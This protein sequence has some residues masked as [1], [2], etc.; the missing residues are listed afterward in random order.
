MNTLS[1]TLL[2]CI[3]LGL[4]SVSAYARPNVLIIISDDAGYADFGFMNELTGRV[5]D[6]PTPHLDDLRAEGTLFSSAYTGSV[7]S[8]SR[9]AITTGFYQNRLG[10]EYNINNLISATARDGHFPETVTIFEWMKHLGYTTGA[11]GKWHI[12]AMADDGARPG[13]R[14]ER[15]GVDTFV[16][17][18]GGSRN[19]DVGVVTAPDQLLRRTKVAPD[20]TITDTV[21]ENQHPWKD[22][23]LTVAFG[24]AAEDFITE[25]HDD[26][27]PFLL[28]AAFTSPHDPLHESPDYDDPRIAGISDPQHRQYASM[29]LTMDKAIGGILE[30]LDDPDRDGNPADSIRDNTFIIF[31]NDNGGPSSN[32]SSNFPLRGR[33]G[34]PEEGGIRVPMF[35]T[36]A[37]IPSNSVYAAPVHSVDFLPTIARLAGA[38]EATTLDGVSLAEMDGVDLI[39]YLNENI[40]TAPHELIVVRREDRVG[41]RKGDWKL[42]AKAGSYRLYNLADDIGETQDLALSEPAI[43]AD[44]LHELNLFDTGSDK[45]RHA[46]L[47]ALPDSINLNDRFIA[48]PPGPSGS[49]FV[50]DLVIVGGSILNGDFNAGAATGIET[51]AQTMAWDNIGTSGASAPAT[52]TNLDVDGTR[53]AILARIDTRTFGLDTGYTLAGG[54]ILHA[55]YEWRDALDWTDAT[56]RV[57]VTLFTTDDDTLTGERTLIESGLSN[58]SQANDT[59][60]PEDHVFSPIPAGFAGKRLFIQLNPELEGS[61]FARLDNF[62]LERGTTTVATEGRFVWGDPLRWIDGDTG[63]DDTLL[64]TDGFPGARLNFPSRPFNYTA[65]NNLE[66]MTGLGFMLNE[67]SFTGADATTLSLDGKG[68]VFA[69]GLDGAE[70]RINMELDNGTVVI[71]P[72]LL[73]MNDLLLTGNGNGTLRIGGMVTDEQQPNQLVKDGEFTLQFTAAAVNASH[74]VVNAG[75]LSFGET[76]GL[77]GVND[78]SLNATLQIDVSAGY[79]D[80]L[81]VDGTLTLA[82][83][84]LEIVDLGGAFPTQA[85]IAV[86]YGALDGEFTSITGLPAGYHADYAYAD[87]SNNRNIAI[88]PNTAFDD[89]AR[90]ISGLEGADANFAADA[91]SDGVANGLAWYLGMADAHASAVQSLP[92]ATLQPG[93]IQFH[94]NRLKAAAGVTSQVF[95]SSDLSAWA[96]LQ[97]GVDGVAIE[98]SPETEEPGQESIIVR[99]PLA[100]PPSGQFLRLEVEQQ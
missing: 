25:H 21:I 50:P 80:L 100:P 49:T 15:Q 58:I 34:D 2:P 77:L 8:P 85:R 95:A 56:D 64:S 84:T 51:F 54:E 32:T 7:C 90:V 9:A 42:V 19:Y 75:T 22:L 37:G 29:M 94:F 41:L 98:V 74:I 43:L 16:G 89:W 47:D 36:G 91:N 1:R 81:A 33:K 72:D 20:G 10:Y 12:G 93:E 65:T 5:T 26:P 17:L 60:Q 62:V 99:V 11:F 18:W 44:L 3:G 52:N 35:M 13:N 31:I 78:L 96:S 59:Y 68:L 70:P 76:I 30:R 38:D 82:G 4:L 23:N 87:G 55:S 53:N 14:P 27:V 67:L 92:Q 46:A 48:L 6:V 73:L 28:Y 71:D 83:A 79:A 45:P 39:P 69:T 86:S 97:H 57:A 66:R 88:V 40:T 61:G 24:L 63:L